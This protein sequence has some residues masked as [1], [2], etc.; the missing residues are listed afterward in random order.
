MRAIIGTQA[1]ATVNAINREAMKSLV[2]EDV[3]EVKLGRYRLARSKNGSV[4]QTVAKL[5]DE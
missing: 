3:G 5:E 2:P 1:A 4:T